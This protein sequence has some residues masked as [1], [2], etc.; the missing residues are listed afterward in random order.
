MASV[1][2]VKALLAEVVQRC[3]EAWQAAEAE[4]YNLGGAIEQAH[5]AADIAAMA[6]DGTAHESAF[7]AVTLLNKAEAEGRASYAQIEEMQQ[8]ILAASEHAQQYIGLL[9]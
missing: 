5:Q 8:S 3:G 1:G 6:Y 2:E 7:A 4:K 9:G